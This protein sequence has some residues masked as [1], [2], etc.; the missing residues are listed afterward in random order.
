MSRQSSDEKVLP[1]W[2]LSVNFTVWL[3]KV[4]KM[5]LFISVPTLSQFSLYTRA[6]RLGPLF[7][8]IPFLTFQEHVYLYWTLSTG[9]NHTRTYH[10][11]IP[12]ECFTH[13]VKPEKKLTQ[14]AS[15][16]HK[17]RERCARGFEFH[18]RN[19][20]TGLWDPSSQDQ[21]ELDLHFIINLN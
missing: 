5:F 19:K 18:Q 2:C 21:S 1:L 10:V 3:I 4:E 6:T 12:A 7:S 9:D 20:C 14:S 8:S 15:R 16:M 11:G 13:T 17:L